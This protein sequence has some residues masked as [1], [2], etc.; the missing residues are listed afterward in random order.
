MQK[1]KDF[2]LLKS[3]RSMQNRSVQINRFLKPTHLYVVFIPENQEQLEILG[4]MVESRKYVTRTYPM[5]YEVL[6]YGE[7]YVDKRAKS[8]S[9]PVVYA[10]IPINA[11][12]PQVPYEK[13]DELYLGDRNNSEEKLMEQVSVYLSE[14]KDKPQKDVVPYG[15]WGR[16]YKPSGRVMVYDT[17]RG[18]NVPLKNAEIQIYNWFFEAYCKTD[19]NGYFKC[20]EKFSREMGVYVTWDN[21]TAKIRS[22]WN[23]I[24]GVRVSDKLGDINRGNNG[25][26][27]VITLKDTFKWSKATVHNAFEKFNKYLTKNGINTKINKLNVWVF[28]GEKKEEGMT[29]MTRK[30]P[31]E[32]L[33]ILFADRIKWLSPITVPV[34]SILNKTQIYP[35]MVLTFND[36]DTEKYDF[37][38]FHESAHAIHALQAGAE[39][40][41]KLSRIELDNILENGKPYSDGTKPNAWSGNNIALCEGWANFMSNKMIYDL[42]EKKEWEEYNLEYF[43]MYTVPFTLK[44]IDR[45][46]GHWFLHGLMWD[47]IDGNSDTIKLFNGETNRSIYKNNNTDNVNISTYTKS[48]VKALYE[49]LGSGVSTGKD[50]KDKLKQKHPK[51]AIAIENLFNAYNY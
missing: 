31:K 33:Y 14:N 47:L 20:D 19:E 11:E 7:S 5:D 23:E 26:K 32:S 45:Q 9:L 36:R 44:N 6:Q 42:Y 29:A 17:N 16:S 48:G 49:M 1:A 37:L 51:Q 27:F 24:I 4:K 12:F 41:V 3:P 13:L 46:K 30:Y 39:F 2:L 10:S 28:G 15:F 38:V 50:L 21:S 8:A 35:D 43:T 22:Y 40:W 18:I 34:A 25:K